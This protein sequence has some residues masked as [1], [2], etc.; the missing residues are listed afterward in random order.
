MNDLPHTLVGV[1]LIVGLLTCRSFAL[2]DLKRGDEAPPIV[3][4]TADGGELETARLRD[5]TLVLLFAEASHGR[6]RLACR[7][8]TV[9]LGTPP[10]SDEPVEW[11]VIL[12]RGGR[13][14]A[15]IKDIGTPGRPPIIAHDVERIAFGAY[16]VK[17]VPTVVVVDRDG[18]VVHAMAGYSDR[19]GDVVFDAMLF[20]T[21]NMSLHRF[22]ETL[23][24]A[25]ISSAD[26]RRSRAQR[27]VQFAHQ[28][29]RRDLLPMAES[30]YLEALELDPDS[31]PARMG[32]GDLL[33]RQQRYAEAEGRFREV[34]A[35]AP[36]SHEGRLGLAL[37][38][39]LGE[40]PRTVEAWKMAEI[41]LR[42]RPRWARAQYLAGVVHEQRGESDEATA[43]YRRAAE[44]LLRR[45]GPDST[46]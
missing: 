27:S 19:F 32:L 37:V 44:L 3:L 30:R 40:P 18:K 8:I 13:A 22:E 43:C 45:L 39:A 24:P 11:I 46:R 23:D 4:P 31:L 17:V 21:G 9:A 5:R 1:A 35:V 16:E 2:T 38:Y 42:Q 34:L 10:L 36:D 41:L 7:Q 33:L 29:V 15:M 28:L 25:T 14:E 12:A 6:T 20:A 26:E